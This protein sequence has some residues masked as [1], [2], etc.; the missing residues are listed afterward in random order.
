MVI[1]H[2]YH[3]N[4]CYNA[5]RNIKKPSIDRS[6]PMI[7]GFCE[8]QR[9][10]NDYDETLNIVRNEKEKFPKLSTNLKDSQRLWI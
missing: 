2:I 4:H 5:V 7:K 9:L 1:A 10:T 8:S 3:H 6:E